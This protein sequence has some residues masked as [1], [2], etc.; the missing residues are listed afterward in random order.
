MDYTRE[1]YGVRASVVSG[2]GHIGDGNIHLNI[3]ANMDFDVEETREL[4][5]EKLMQKLVDIGGSISAEHG[6]GTM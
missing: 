2:Y 3:V 1:L 5:E 4:C 6:I